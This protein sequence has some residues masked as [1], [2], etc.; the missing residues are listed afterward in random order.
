MNRT[1]NADFGGAGTTGSSQQGRISTSRFGWYYM[2]KQNVKVE[3]NQVELRLTETT[4]YWDMDN[5]NDVSSSSGGS[6]NTTGHHFSSAEAG[7]T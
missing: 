6:I 1:T 7:Y 3:N 4:T 5:T 2:Y